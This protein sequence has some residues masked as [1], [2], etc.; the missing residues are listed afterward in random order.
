M[1]LAF[2]QK[3]QYTGKPT[4]F[5]EKVLA[6]LEFEKDETNYLKE[7]IEREDLAF[8]VYTNC[9]PKKH[10]IR[11][12]TFKR[13]KVGMDIHF[14]I[15]NRQKN[16]YQFAPIRKV[17]SIQTIEIIYSDDETTRATE[18]PIVKVDGR[19]VKRKHLPQLAM[20]DGFQTLQ[21]F[22]DW[23][24]DSFTG[25]IIHWTEIKY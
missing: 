20:N 11:A 22:F 5:P 15:N 14:V 17:V 13:W 8:Y 19:K 12:D 16:R 24:N 3:N 18:N 7:I 6:S 1:T 25:I 21:E 23:F 4:F 10:T 2:T 9:T